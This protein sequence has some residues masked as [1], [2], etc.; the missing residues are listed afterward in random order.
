M[1]DNSWTIKESEEKVEGQE[2][3]GIYLLVGQVVV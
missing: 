3:S 1:G 2:I